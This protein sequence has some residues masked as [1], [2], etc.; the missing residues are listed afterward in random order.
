MD[1]P[2]EEGNTRPATELYL[3]TRTRNATRTNL[4]KLRGTLSLFP[5]FLLLPPPVSLT[6]SLETIE[7]FQIKDWISQISDWK[8]VFSYRCVLFIYITEYYKFST[9]SKLSKINMNYRKKVFDIYIYRIL[10]EWIFDSKLVEL[11]NSKT[12]N[13]EES[14]FEYINVMNFLV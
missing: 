6:C 13:S 14:N 12:L 4:Y 2:L 1:F 11:L 3:V 7:T 8:K 5:L 10:F 9:Y